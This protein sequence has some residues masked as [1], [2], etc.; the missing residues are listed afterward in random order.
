MERSISIYPIP[1][2]NKISI[3]TDQKIY[4]KNYLIYD[5][6]GKVMITGKMVSDN[7]ILDISQLTNGL[8][9]F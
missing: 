4:E 1:S 3:S 7:T 5:T 2:S 9:F 6:K 8:Y